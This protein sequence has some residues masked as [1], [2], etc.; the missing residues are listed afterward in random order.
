MGATDPSTTGLFTL[1]VALAVFPATYLTLLRSPSEM[2][3]VEK[4]TTTD[5][6]PTIFTCALSCSLTTA[7]VQ[8]SAR[9]RLPQ[10]ARVLDEAVARDPRFLLAWCLLS[11]VHA[12]VYWYGIDH[13]SARLNLA[14]AAVQTALRLQPDAG[15]VHLALAS[16]YY[17]GFH[18][19]G[20]ARTEL[21][22]A[23]RKIITPR[24]SNTLATSTAGRAIGKKPPATWS[25]PLS[26]WTRTT[27]TTLSSSRNW[28]GPTAAKGA[29]QT[30][31]ELMA[32]R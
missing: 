24:Y 30:R 13:T 29:I 16:Y 18:D 1:L 10:A 31:S 19:F 8:S 17:H 7:R 28:Q 2:A 32:A 12:D 11:R 23:R 25:A 6:P 21:A 5:L 4:P 15:E 9:R 22:I 3:P 20:R 26:C 27:R 14:N